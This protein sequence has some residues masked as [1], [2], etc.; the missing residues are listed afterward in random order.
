MRF[1]YIL[2][3]IQI[4]VIMIYKGTLY[5]EIR[6]QFGLKIFTICVS[7]DRILKTINWISSN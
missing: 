5:S 2:E 7:S 6:Y 4:K 1:H 3:I